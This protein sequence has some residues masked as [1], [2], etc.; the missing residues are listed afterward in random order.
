[1]VQLESNMHHLLERLH[2]LPRADRKAIVAHL[3]FD[4][5]LQLER[6]QADE[7]HTAEVL[8]QGNPGLLYSPWLQGFVA[9]AR[10]Q[11]EENVLTSLTR[12]AIVEV[13]ASDTYDPEP[14]AEPANRSL[15][16][17]VWHLISGAGAGR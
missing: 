3:S 12:E 2:C 8:P 10:Q 4:E 9:M 16:D 17:R 13:C 15:L 14:V 6:L 1:M 7:S 5:R 11:G